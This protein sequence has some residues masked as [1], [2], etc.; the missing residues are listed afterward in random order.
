MH[1]VVTQWVPLNR[2][3]DQGIAPKDYL[4]VYWQLLAAHMSFATMFIMIIV[5]SYLYGLV[6]F[7]RKSLVHSLP[8]PLLAF[9]SLSFV[10]HWF[11]MVSIGS[12][13][14]DGTIA[15][16]GNGTIGLVEFDQ[17]QALGLNVIG[18]KPKVCKHIVT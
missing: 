5:T 6:Y 10:F 9:A 18:S 15:Q 12:T 8:T 11:L 1:L 3:Q 7:L 14:K 17:R 2:F 13:V 16:I 4:L